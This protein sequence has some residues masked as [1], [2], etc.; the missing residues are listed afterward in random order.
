M[1]SSARE[2]DKE[3]LYGVNATITLK[4][5]EFIGTEETGFMNNVPAKVI[6]YILRKPP[7]SFVAR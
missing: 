4:G 1:F 7:G 5:S 3:L 6:L 2:K